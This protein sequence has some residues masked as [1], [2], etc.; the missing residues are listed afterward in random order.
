MKLFGCILGLHSAIS[1]I[2][3]GQRSSLFS[4]YSLTIVD[5]DKSNEHTNYNINSC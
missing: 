1:E 3:L 4:G 2:K 5:I